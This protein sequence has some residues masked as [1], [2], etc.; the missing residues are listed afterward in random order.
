MEEFL[1]VSHFASCLQIV[2]SR[3]KTFFFKKTKK[4]YQ[5]FVSEHV[6]AKVGAKFLDYQSNTKYSSGLYDGYTML[7]NFRFEGRVCTMLQIF[8]KCEVK[9]NSLRIFLPIRFYV[10][11]FLAKFRSQK[12][13]IFTVLEGQD[14]DFGKDSGLE[15]AKNSQ[16]QN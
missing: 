9:P 12:T 5:N 13:A 6:W 7:C 15:C 11:F 1:F 14:F 10:K 16:N 3:K 4:I 2:F 8:S